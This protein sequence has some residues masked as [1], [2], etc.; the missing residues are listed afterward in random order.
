[1]PTMKFTSSRGYRYRKGGLYLGVSPFLKNPIGIETEKHAITFGAPRSGKGVALIVPNLLRWHH[2]ALV[3]DPKGEAAAATALH[4]EKEFG[5]AVHVLDPF[6]VADVPE[7]MK[8]RLNLFDNISEESGRGFEQIRAIADGLVMRHDPR[9][10]HWDGGS[11]ALLAGVIAHI[12]SGQDQSQKNLVGMRKALLNQEAFATMIENMALNPAFGGLA[13]AGAGRVTM[14]GSEA[15]HFKS[16]ADSN[17]LWL[18]SPA[19]QHPLSGSTFQLSDLKHKPTTVYLVLPTELLDE[20]GRFLRLF[21]QCA[22]TAMAEGGTAGREC[23]FLLD[24]F[25]SLGH[26]D[27]IAKTASSMPGYGLKLWPILHDIGQLYQLYEKDG[28]GTFF[29]CSDAQMFFGNTDPDTLDFVSSMI[30]AKYHADAWGRNADMVG[31]PLMSAREIREHVAKKKGDKVARRMI[32]FLQGDDIL[33][34]NLKPFF[35]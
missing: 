30:G 15:G 5:Q 25:Y 33:S 34:I 11:V 2:N 19:F 8:A 23:L 22:L 16:G 12:I 32:V 28:A 4:R 35:E 14:T 21:V 18:D 26:I 10:G 31:K 29:G 17:T 20:H 1:M 27:K 24:E 7:R 9:G 3:I 6:N 13:Q